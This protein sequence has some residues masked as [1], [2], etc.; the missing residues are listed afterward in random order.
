MGLGLRMLN[1]RNYRDMLLI[2]KISSNLNQHMR[3]RCAYCELDLGTGDSEVVTFVA[4][5]EEKHSDRI[6]EKDL[7]TYRKMIRK[8]TS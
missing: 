3:K 8:V 6:D 4:H 5:L 7:Q 1:P 2:T